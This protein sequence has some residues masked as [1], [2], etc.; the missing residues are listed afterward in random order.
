MALCRAVWMIQARG[1]SGT[2]ADAPL[3]HRG[4]KGFLRRLFRQVE[5]AHHADQR[6]HNPAPI[7]AVKRFD[8]RGGIRGIPDCKNFCAGCRFR[9]ARR[10]T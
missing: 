8:S 10:S 7:G 2:P 9:L 3:V 5:V 1:N 6:G 4:R